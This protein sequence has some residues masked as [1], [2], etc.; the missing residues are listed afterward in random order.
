MGWGR[1]IASLVLGVMFAVAAC[2]SNLS[3]Q[4][5]GMGDDVHRDV[6]PTT[7]P[8][9]PNGEA[10]PD[11]PFARVDGS[12][13]YGP[14]YDAYAALTICGSTRSSDASTHESDSARPAAA[15]ES[16]AADADDGMTLVDGAS[17]G[18]D[19]A[20][21]AGCVPLP[22]ACTNEPDCACLFRALAAEIPCP[23]PHCSGTDG[24]KIYC[25]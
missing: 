24:F 16:G 15:H 23:Y 4:P 6:D 22:A 19:A 13:A 21:S 7:L 12:G 3:G 25:P 2:S 9:Q 20:S 17:Y 10:P 14:E 5:L 8:P 18:G 1:F 11:S